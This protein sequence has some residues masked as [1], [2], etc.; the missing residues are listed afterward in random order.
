M[1]IEQTAVKEDQHRFP[2]D[3]P[4]GVETKLIHSAALRPQEGGFL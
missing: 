3:S 2:L 1:S 4:P